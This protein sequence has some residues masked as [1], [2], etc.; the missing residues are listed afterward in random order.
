[1]PCAALAKAATLEAKIPSDAHRLTT[2]ACPLRP[3]QL[4]RVHAA[5]S[6][7]LPIYQAR[8]GLSD[9][10]PGSGLDVACLGITWNAR[11]L[12]R[13][14]VL[15]TPPAG[16]A[17]A[18]SLGLEIPT[19]EP[20]LTS[21][22]DLRAAS[23][24]A[25]L[26]ASLAAQALPTSFAKSKPQRRVVEFGTSLM[27][28]NHSSHSTMSTHNGRSNIKRRRDSKQ[29]FQRHLSSIRVSGSSHRETIS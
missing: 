10:S 1:L 3:L 26:A 15:L 18:S 21:G 6:R 25:S 11:S 17:H 23:F 12:S 9:G 20:S 4:A 8:V 27:R 22:S 29:P 5:Q 28:S 16:N 7:T 24:T 2:T 13:F 19:I 14:A